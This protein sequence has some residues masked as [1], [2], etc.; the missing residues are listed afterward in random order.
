MGEHGENEQA[1]FFMQAVEGFVILWILHGDGKHIALSPDG[2]AA[3]FLRQRG[4]DE[5][6]HAGG[7]FV[8]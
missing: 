2:E 4:I 8:R 1:S 6:L 5:T 3:Q 7:Q